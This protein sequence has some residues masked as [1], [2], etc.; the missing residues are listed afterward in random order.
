MPNQL[1]RAVY[2]TTVLAIRSGPPSDPRR[3]EFRADDE[4]FFADV[5]VNGVRHVV[6]FH[7]RRD[8][9]GGYSGSVALSAAFPM[10][11]DALPFLGA[12]AERITKG[13]AVS[14]P[15]HAVI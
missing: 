4:T 7:L 12:V 5:V 3:R 15:I 9:G 6:E 11:K 13:D 8:T 1:V 2:D 14:F 10:S